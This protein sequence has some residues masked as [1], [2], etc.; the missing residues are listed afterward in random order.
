MQVFVC[1]TLFSYSFSVFEAWCYEVI[2][3]L[4]LCLLRACVLCL[5]RLIFGSSLLADCVCIIDFGAVRCCRICVSLFI[6]CCCE[7]ICWFYLVC[8]A[9]VRFV[10]VL[11]GFGSGHIGRACA[12][13]ASVLAACSMLSSLFMQTCLISHLSSRFVCG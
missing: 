12:A 13:F 11:S 8:V 10:S 4:Y 3:R 9:R 1:D 7:R 2:R 6:V 5:C